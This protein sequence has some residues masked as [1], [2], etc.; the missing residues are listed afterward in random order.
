MVAWTIYI[1]RPEGRR[2]GEREGRGKREKE[3]ER[4]INWLID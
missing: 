3:R 1:P 2:G 4:D